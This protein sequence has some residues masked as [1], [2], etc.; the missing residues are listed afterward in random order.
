MDGNYRFLLDYGPNRTQPIEK[1]GI[2]AQL[3]RTSVFGVAFGFCI[4][5]S[6]RV[7]DYQTAHSSIQCENGVGDYNYRSGVFSMDIYKIQN[8]I[9]F[10]DSLS[11]VAGTPPPNVTDSNIVG[12]G[13]P[14]IS[15]SFILLLSFV[16]ITLFCGLL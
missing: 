9:A 15:S 12:S 2:A 3:N 6:S 16:L 8:P 1:C 7:A 5:G 13:A 14:V 4:S 11:Q 10:Q